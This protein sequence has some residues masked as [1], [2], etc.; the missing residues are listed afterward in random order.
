MMQSIAAALEWVAAGLGVLNVALLVRRSVWNYPFGMAMVAFYAFVFWGQ[1]LYAEAGLQVFFFVAQGWGWWLWLRT[2]HRE[3]E[4]DSQVP[5]RWLDGWSRLVW[6]VA[7]L[8][9]A[10]NLGLVLGRFTD[11]A[12]PFA[13]AAIAG[14]SVTAQ[15]LLAYRRVE[16]WV[17]WIVV[18]V[19]AVALYLN[20]G[21]YPTA[22]LY[23]LMLVLSVLGL[24]EWIRAAREEAAAA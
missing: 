12:M 7:T 18:D 5:V 11:A 21:L 2:L 13:D 24:F 1:K 22:V 16:N 3:G 8:A 4:A 19:A 10:L 14:A 17:V 20:R 23:A 9:I 15:I 6:G